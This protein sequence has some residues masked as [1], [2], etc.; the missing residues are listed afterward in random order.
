ML[1]PHRRLEQLAFEH[2][3]PSGRSTVVVEVDALARVP[4]EEPHV[5]VVG[6]RQ[7]RNQRSSG[8][9]WARRRY[10]SASRPRSR[11][12]SRISNGASTRGAPSIHPDSLVIVRVEV[13]EHDRA[14]VGGGFQLRALHEDGVDVAVPQC[15]ELVGNVDEP[16]SSR[17]GRRSRARR[18]TRPRTRRAWL[19]ELARGA[20]ARAARRACPAAPRG[21]SS[22]GSRSL[23][24]RCRVSSR[25]HGQC[26]FRACAVEDTA[27]GWVARDAAEPA[28]DR[29]P[30]ERSAPRV[31]SAGATELVVRQARQ[32]APGVVHRQSVDSTRNPVAQLH[33]THGT[34][35]I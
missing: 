35:E 28:A 14:D 22:H 25:G 8:V 20:V 21:R 30:R 19:S 5:V 1:P 11:S 18:R 17:S 33:V 3:E 10:V 4:P 31:R 34:R 9:C 15:G 26:L 16:A 27:I 7:R 32:L 24:V 12:T 6:D 29:D 23:G 13:D 2:D